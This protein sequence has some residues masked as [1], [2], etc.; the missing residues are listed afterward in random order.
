MQ[1]DC[2]RG[3]GYGAGYGDARSKG[4]ECDGEGV[5]CQVEGD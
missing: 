1:Y 2:Y 3:A 4:V 5:E